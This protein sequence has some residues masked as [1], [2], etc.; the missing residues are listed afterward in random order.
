MEKKDYLTGKK[1]LIVDDEHDILETLEDL[2]SMCETVKAST[3]DEA[4]TLL[5]TQEFDIAILDIMGVNGY[6]LL[7]IAKSKNIITVMLTA[8][9]LTLD[10]IKRSYIEG[11]DSYI[12]K[13]EMVNIDKFLNDILEAKEKGENTW[14]NWYGRL[15]SFCER[16][17][18]KDWQS[19]DKDFWEKMPFY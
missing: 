15:A 17:F 1:V 18:G 14:A 4:E 3:F 8:R 13:E 10:D 6:Q 16:K 12:H 9:A 2:L 5:E 19:S 7:E 11:A